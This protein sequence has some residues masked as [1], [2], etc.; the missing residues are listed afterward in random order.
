MIV[1]SL[2]K[3]ALTRGGCSNCHWNA[4]CF[5]KSQSGGKDTIIIRR[6]NAGE[7]ISCYIRKPPRNV[8]KFLPSNFLWARILPAA[9]S[10]YWMVENDVKLAM[11]LCE[12]VIGGSVDLVVFQ[13]DKLIFWFFKTWLSHWKYLVV[14]F[15]FST[16]D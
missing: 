12:C 9:H 8:T 3:W 2:C 10:K 14:F 5:Y 13:V 7:H 16:L 11:W 1:F 6:R 4:T 15:V